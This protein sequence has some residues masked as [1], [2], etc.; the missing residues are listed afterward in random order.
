VHL[1]VAF[2]TINDAR[3][4]FVQEGRGVGCVDFLGPLVV[5][6]DLI[7]RYL[8]VPLQALQE[9]EAETIFVVISGG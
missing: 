6:K 2:E 7:V 3:V 1:L 4:E 5:L 9:A 8:V